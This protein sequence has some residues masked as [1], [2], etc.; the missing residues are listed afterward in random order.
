MRSKV[1]LIYTGGT[2]GMIRNPQTEALEPFDFEHLLKNVPELEQ[3]DT[4]IDTFQF[5]P[6]I[7]S[8]DMTP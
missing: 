1:L 7:D 4:K 6:P 2:I 5:S 8:S 3:F